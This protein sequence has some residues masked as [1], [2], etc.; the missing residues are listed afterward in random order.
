MSLYEGFNI[1]EID[2]S[3][4]MNHLLRLPVT[5]DQDLYHKTIVYGIDIKDKKDCVDILSC[6][7]YDNLIM[8]WKDFG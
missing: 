2:S 4:N 5:K 1:W 6:S 3:L 7:F 8:H